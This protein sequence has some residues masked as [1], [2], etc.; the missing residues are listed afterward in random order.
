[1]ITVRSWAVYG[2]LAAIWGAL[3][4]WQAAEHI[5]VSKQLHQNLTDLAH[6]KADSCAKL[7]RSRRFA[8]GVIS[9]ERL[10]GALNV[11]VETNELRAV[12]L[13]NNA[14]EVVASAGTNID[15]PPD[16]EFEQ[17]A[18][19]GGGTAI[20]KYPIDLGTNLGTNMAAE[21]VI[22]FEEL[23]TINS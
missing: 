11:L 3:L 8:G 13:L 1:M 10:E 17:A 6:T 19:W 20:L 2:M 12:E 4:G 22:P 14:N 7:M 9:K 5:R 23:K 21:L 18:Y 15:L 16:S